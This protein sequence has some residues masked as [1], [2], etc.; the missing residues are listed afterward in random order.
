[1][2]NF[3]WQDFL[4]VQLSSIIATFAVP[5]GFVSLM[6]TPEKVSASQDFKTQWRE[7]KDGPSA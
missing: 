4:L 6:R 3:G 7:M 5:L 1:M 2:A